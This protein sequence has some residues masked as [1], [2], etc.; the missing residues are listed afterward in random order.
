MPGTGAGVP[1]RPSPRASAFLSERRHPQSKIPGPLDNGP[2]LEDLAQGEQN[3][4]TIRGVRISAL[5]PYKR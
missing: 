2:I 5:R 4:G 1:E 3:V